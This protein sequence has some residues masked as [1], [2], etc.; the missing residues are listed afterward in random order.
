MSAELSSGGELANI[1]G[2]A[3]AWQRYRSEVRHIEAIPR[4]AQAVYAE[5]ARNGDTEAAHALVIN[6]LPWVSWKAHLTYAELNPSHSSVEDLAA[7]ANLK[8]L[9]CLP[10]ALEA[11][12]PVAYLMS[13]AAFEMKHYVFYSDPMI[14]R[15]KDRPLSQQRHWETVSGDEGEFPLFNRV[16]AAS[17]R[18]VSAETL[19]AESRERH[20]PLYNAIGELPANWQRSL[21]TFY[22]LTDEPAGTAMDVGERLGVHEKTVERHIRSAKAEL[23]VKLG[24]MMLEQE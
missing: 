3:S 12:D 17:T 21:T 16:A 7:H 13:I 4:E 14:R 11:N 20:A 8:M 10:H 19:E 6:C 5:A 24:A 1:P 23:A 22:G 18:L 9:E 2:D 15:P